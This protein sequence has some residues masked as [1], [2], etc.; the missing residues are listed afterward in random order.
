MTKPITTQPTTINVSE[1]PHSYSYLLENVD[2]N[3]IDFKSETKFSRPKT[4]RNQ[5]EKESIKIRKT[6]SNQLNQ[7]VTD[8]SCLSIGKSGGESCTTFSTSRIKE[9]DSDHCLNFASANIEA[10]SSLKSAVPSIMPESRS[11]SLLH[12]FEQPK[13]REAVA[14]ISTGSHSTAE[15]GLSPR[16]SG[17]GTN[18][19]GSQSSSSSSSSPC[20]QICNQP[21]ENSASKSSESNNCQ[22]NCGPPSNDSKKSC[23]SSSGSNASMND[24][25]ADDK[26]SIC[27]QICC[28]ALKEIVMPTPRKKT[29]QAIA[30]SEPA[31]SVIKKKTA[32]KKRCGSEQT[33]DKSCS[34]NISSPPEYKAGCGPRPVA[35]HCDKP[36]APKT[37]CNPDKQCTNANKTS[38]CG[39]ASREAIKCKKSDSN[40]SEAPKNSCGPNKCMPSQ[41]Q[42][43]QNRR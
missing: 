4:I 40:K 41:P 43:P 9:N 19:C 22:K 13:E 20:A 3:P 33:V 29:T 30:P 6:A 39:S 10:A 35:L 26:T 27:K 21:T 16:R 23:C 32:C 17:G 42:R 2:L 24:C 15:I 31:K 11:N 18:G 25:S 37:E 1:P 28:Q 14:Q 5:P 7:K 8:A 36:E 34:T 38:T 12:L